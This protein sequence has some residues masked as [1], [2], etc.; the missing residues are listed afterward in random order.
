MGEEAL[1]FSPLP[2]G[3]PLLPALL[4]SQARTHDRRNLR[5]DIKREFF[6][7]NLLVRIHSIIVMIR[8]TGL[9]PWEFEFLF[10]DSIPSNFLSGGV[11][12]GAAVWIYRGYSKVRT[13]TALGPYGRSVPRSIGPT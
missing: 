11:R 9:A 12:A 6:I 2:I 4:S 8:W 7:D 10:P 1:T 13:H 3:R 5:V